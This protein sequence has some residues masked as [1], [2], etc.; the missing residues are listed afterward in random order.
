MLHEG[1]LSYDPDKKDHDYSIQKE[2]ISFAVKNAVK[3]SLIVICSDVI[4]RCFGFGT[5]L[6]RAGI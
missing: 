4:S 2:A 6:Q 1:I 5:S 3:G